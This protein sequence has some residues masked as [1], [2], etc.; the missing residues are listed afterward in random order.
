MYQAC[1]VCDW[2]RELRVSHVVFAQSALQP[3]PDSDVCY[4]RR[5]PRI[6]AHRVKWGGLFHVKMS[7]VTD[8]FCIALL[9]LVI[10]CMLHDRFV[11][12][13]IT[14]QDELENNPGV[15]AEPVAGAPVAIGARSAASIVG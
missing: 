9:V 8:W 15:G 12:C 7:C 3:V 14:C 13:C 6:G 1:I 2:P 5:V 11:L 4:E 10:S